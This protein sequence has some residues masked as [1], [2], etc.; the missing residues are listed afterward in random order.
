MAAIP[1]RL[2][3][4]KCYLEGIELLGVTDVDLPNLE[5][6]TETIKGAGLLGETETPTVGQYSAMSM[7]INWRNLVRDITPLL[8]PNGHI[9][10]FR[11]SIQSTD[12][13]TGLLSTKQLRVLTR[14]KPKS[15]NIGKG[16]V[17]AAMESSSEFTVEYLLTILG[18]TPVFEYDPFNYICRIGGLDILGSARSDIN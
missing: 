2:I 15:T 14:A 16:D 13:Q 7:T 9:L 4:F 12:S 8:D 18:G 11:G 10:E 5:A 6:M 17:S 1:E 3:G